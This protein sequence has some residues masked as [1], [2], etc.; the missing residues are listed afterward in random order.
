MKTAAVLAVLALSITG[1]PQDSFK[2]DDEGFIRN[3]LVLA[4]IASE[5]EDAGAAEVDKEQVKDE[6]KL[7]PKAGDKATAGG[8]ELTWKAHKA[9]DYFIDFRASFGAERGEDVVGYAVAYVH[10]DAEMTGLRILMGS[11]DEAKLYLNGKCVVKFESGRTIDK[12][13]DA[14]ENVTLVK[15]Q[16]VI[17]FKVINEKNNWAGCVRFTDKAGAAL[18]TLKVTLAPQ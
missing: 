17:V 15:G 12:D 4:P 9:A 18:K 5:N 16:N 3:W 1:A 11:N 2:V 6:A 13:Q 8:K 10:A 7:K 14:G